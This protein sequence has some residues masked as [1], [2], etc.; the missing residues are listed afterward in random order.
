MEKQVS[1][2]QKRYKAKRLFLTKKYTARQIGEMVGVTDATMSKWIKQ[3][4]WKDPETTDLLP[5]SQVFGFKYKGFYAYL[6]NN[7][8]Q[9][10]DI[11]NFELKNFIDTNRG[12]VAKQTA[13]LN[14]L[15]KSM[16]LDEKDQS[17]LFAEIAGKPIDDIAQLKYKEAEYMIEYLKEYD[18][19][20]ELVIKKVNP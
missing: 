6:S 13:Q 20:V 18:K 12:I 16:G 19:V 10:I 14:R 3:N 9:L 15:I 8:P 4:G 5:K 17:I 1:R 7:N 11:L 2:R